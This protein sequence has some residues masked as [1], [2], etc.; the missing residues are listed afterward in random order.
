MPWIALVLACLVGGCSF[1]ADYSGTVVCGTNGECP[2]GLECGPG[3]VCR[4]PRMDAAVDTPTDT[5]PDG[6]PQ[7]ALTCVQPGIL[8]SGS[9]VTGSTTGHSNNMQSICSSNP[10][11]AV[12]VVYKITTPAANKQLVVSISNSS[13]N[14]YVINACMPMPNT[15]ACLGGTVATAGNPISVAAALAT[16]YWVVVDSN[17]AAVNGAYTLQVDIQ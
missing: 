8:T 16:D 11:F 17:L 4:P 15:P 10:Q 6:N 13:L 14:A 7:P 2:S 1:D 12:D 9:A 3:M 5:T